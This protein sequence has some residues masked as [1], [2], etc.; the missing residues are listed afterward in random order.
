MRPVFLAMLLLGCSEGPQADPQTD[1]QSGPQ[2]TPATAP[3]EATPTPSPDSDGGSQAGTTEAPAAAPPADPR[4]VEANTQGYRAYKQGDLVAALAAFRQ[5]VELDD[6]YALAHYNLACTL[7]LLRRQG[8][9]CEHDAYED[10]VLD[11]LAR[12]VQLDPGRAERMRTDSDLDDVRD[13][14][15]YRLLDGGDMQSEAGL[16]A[17][18]SGL[19]LFGPAQGAYGAT[20]R[21]V[22]QPDGVVDIYRRTWDADGSIGEWAEGKGR[23][24]PHGTKL[25]ITLDGDIQ[26]VQ[27]TEE[28]TLVVGDTALWYDHPHECSA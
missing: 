28:G 25:H 6:R 3:T 13:T 18:M 26:E 22:L 10:A 12:A 19:E 23:W 17:L 9:V 21:I 16:K 4:A 20:S 24:S 8:K 27:P 1:P 14:M 2:A 11:H 5:A 15:R 7:A